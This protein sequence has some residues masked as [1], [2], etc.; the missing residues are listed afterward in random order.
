MFS[1]TV[2]YDASPIVEDR[3][4]LTS[5][6]AVTCGAAALALVVLITA[7]CFYCSKPSQAPYKKSD[8]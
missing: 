8:F 7:V 4:V 2:V 6:I 1:D 5:I 3:P